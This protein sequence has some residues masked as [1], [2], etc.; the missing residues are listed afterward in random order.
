MMAT[1]EL[2]VA[3][4]SRGVHRAAPDCPLGERPVHGRVWLVRRIPA[5]ISDNEVL[6]RFAT[7]RI[8]DPG[9]Y[10]VPF[11]ALGDGKTWRLPERPTVV[12][13][14]QPAFIP[15]GPRSAQLAVLING[16]PWGRRYIKRHAVWSE[17]CRL[18]E[19]LPKG[20]GRAAPWPRPQLPSIAELQAALTDGAY[21]PP[22]QQDLA[23]VA[24][25]LGRRIA[26]LPTVDRD[27]ADRLRH[28]LAAALLEC[29]AQEGAR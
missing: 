9:D 17:V 13:S 2:R 18:P 29:R 22:S 12:H 20:H 7:T 16:G 15:H 28:H 14:R 21:A 10:V 23:A 19:P 26:R 27:R 5:E 25:E 1:R 11:D 24:Q 6:G 3:E 8:G 4:S